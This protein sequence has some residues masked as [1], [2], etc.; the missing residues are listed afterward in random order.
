MNRPNW[1]A[2]R[3]RGSDNSAEKRDADLVELIDALAARVAALEARD[4][5]ADLLAPAREAVACPKCRASKFACDDH[6]A[7][8]LGEAPTGAEIQSLA[9]CLLAEWSDVTFA[10]AASKI[11]TGD[12]VGGRFVRLAQRAFEHIPYLKQLRS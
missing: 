11:S 3:F 5:F 9:T 4:G 10:E 1:M 7:P 8:A 6:Y 2:T 12:S